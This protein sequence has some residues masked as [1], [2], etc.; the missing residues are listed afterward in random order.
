MGSVS[1]TLVGLVGLEPA[2]VAA[3]RKALSAER[4]VVAELASAREAAMLFRHV[5]PNLLVTDT[6][7]LA[8]EPDL[9]Q[10]L[11]ARAG[12]HGTAVLV[13]D[14]APD[15]AM[16]ASVRATLQHVRARRR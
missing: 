15:P 13:V 11:R 12:E 10:T 5:I 9:W 6:A 1:A 3:V 4:A 16:T 14:T 2:T 7:Y 8:A